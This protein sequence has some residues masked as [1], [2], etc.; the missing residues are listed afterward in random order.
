[1]QSIV[2]SFF[3]KIIFRWLF[4]TNYKDIGTLYLILA[5]TVG[6]T[7]IVLPELKENFFPLK[8]NHNSLD[9]IVT[10]H[11]YILI[12]FI[13]IP[14]LVNGVGNRFVPP[15]INAPNMSFPRINSISFW[16]LF[17]AF[18]LLI[19]SVLCKSNASVDLAF[20]S[21]LLSYVSAI[22]MATN[23]IFTIISTIIENVSLHKTPLFVWVVLILAVLQIFFSFELAPKI[24]M[25]L[26]N[27]KCVYFTILQLK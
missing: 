25:M 1:M 7:G 3:N 20:F 13:V 2:K 22:S 10:G 9:L 4:S 6:V 18:F 21:L 5:G 16:L 24:F 14:V 12:F 8:Y 19:E 23:F 17:T 27:Y 15:M 26:I 11:T